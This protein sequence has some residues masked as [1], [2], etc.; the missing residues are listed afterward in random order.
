VNGGVLLDEQR[1]A[2]RALDN[3]VGADVQAFQNTCGVAI[4]RT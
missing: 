3:R 4:A 1:C 2:L